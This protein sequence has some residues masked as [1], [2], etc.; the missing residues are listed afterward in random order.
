[1]TEFA[2]NEE[3]RR[4]WKENG[5]L[6]PGFVEAVGPDKIAE[7]LNKDCFRPHEAAQ[8]AGYMQSSSDFSADTQWADVRR[9]LGL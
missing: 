5:G 3:A 8:L 1:M 7:M 2:W 4:L 6:T 9:Q